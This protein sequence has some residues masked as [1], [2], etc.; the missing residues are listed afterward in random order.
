MS[1]HKPIKL[2]INW[3]SDI[4]NIFNLFSPPHSQSK[5]YCLLICLLNIIVSLSL[6]IK[7]FIV[8]YT[9]TYL[10]FPFLKLSNRAGGGERGDCCD[11]D[12]CGF[13]VDIDAIGSIKSVAVCSFSLII[14]WFT[15]TIFTLFIPYYPLQFSK[16]SFSS[17]KKKIEKPNAKRKIFILNY[18]KL[19]NRL[20][21]KYLNYFAYI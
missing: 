10:V 18:L 12:I 3:T 11:T 4:L 20:K 8:Q 5:S 7:I 17:G 16:C 9:C 15:S 2:N 13:V 21:C 1:V 6:Q 14:G 19:L